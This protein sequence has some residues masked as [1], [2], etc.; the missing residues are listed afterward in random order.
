MLRI[1]MVLEDYG[2]LMFLQTV[3][4]KMGF[5]VDAIQ[6]P[7]SFNDSV[8]RMNPDV[9]VMTAHGKKVNGVE[10]AKGVKRVRGIPHVI[11]I[12]TPGAVKN[13]DQAVWL[14]SPVGAMDLL[15]TIADVGQLDKAGMADKFSKLHLQEG[16]SEARILRL[17]ENQ[18]VEDMLK[19]LDNP[20]NF[21]SSTSLTAEERKERYKKFLSE[22]RPAQ[23]G[24]GVKQVQE[25]IK[26][27]RKDESEEELAELERERK[28]FVEHL[29][30][31]KS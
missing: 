15:N 2:E 19:A 20:G 12:T 26:S 8:L 11:L 22:E 21:D 4:K 1:L 7:R 6:N 14:D 18:P 3:L 10:L 24:F 27:L 5:D 25:H 28:A 31:K 23:I 17:N 13:D 29:F 16:V 9:L 30:R